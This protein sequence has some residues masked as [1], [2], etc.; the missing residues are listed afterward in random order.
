VGELL[1]VFGARP[2]G[3]Q[4]EQAL[5]EIRALHAEVKSASPRGWAGDCARADLL[6]A[7][8]FSRPGPRGSWGLELQIPFDLAEALRRAC[9]PE[10][11]LFL[12]L[13]ER[14][15]RAL[16]ARARIDLGAV[17]ALGTGDRR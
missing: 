4:Y 2:L 8:L 11:E 7:R 14:E 10:V 17:P 9:E 5:A 13:I 6:A 1:A 3:A 16:L 15:A 12:P